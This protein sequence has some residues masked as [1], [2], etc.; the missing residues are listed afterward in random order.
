MCVDP[1]TQQKLIQTSDINYETKP[2]VQTALPDG[3]LVIKWDTGPG[4]GDQH[5]SHYS[6]DFLRTHANLRWR[7]RSNFNDRRQVL[8]DRRLMTQDVLW[9]D[10]KDYMESDEALFEAVRHLS[11]YG[12]VFLRN[13]PE[14]LRRSAVEGIAKRIGNIKET[15]YGRTWDV[16]SVKD[17]KNIAYT[18]LNLGLHMDLLYFESPPGL[19]FLHCIRNSVK[20][21]SSLFADGFR[22]AE[23][24]RLA[25]EQFF[26]ALCDFPVT[27]HYKN[28]GHH[29]HYTR[30]TVVLEKSTYLRQPR[31]DHMNWSPPFQAPI[32]AD[33]TGKD[34]STFRRW[35]HA[36]R[37][38]GKSIEDPQSQLELRLNEGECVIFNNRRV[39]HG[40]RE[41]DPES[42]DR[43]LKGTYVDVDAFLSKFRTLSQRFKGGM[44]NQSEYRDD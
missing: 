26:Q 38:I 25:S 18:P 19:Q 31:I 35:L 6:F 23:A 24:V 1:S 22:A 30:P 40:R 21:G 17:A 10:H 16:K 14:D 20:G 27:F 28:D 7:L 33:T 37:A 42:G 3:A 43:W 41:F 11:I 32:E 8:W 39:L 13:I 4:V 44:D 34:N 2:V 36:I 5:I 12:L 9:I 15:F 29:Y